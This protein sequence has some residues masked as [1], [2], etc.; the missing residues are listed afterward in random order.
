LAVGPTE[1]ILLGVLAALALA[2]FAV[3]F[4]VLRKVLSLVRL[5]VLLGVGSTALVVGLV[6]VWLWIGAAS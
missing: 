3:A 2:G 6:A 1:L 5:L 4:W